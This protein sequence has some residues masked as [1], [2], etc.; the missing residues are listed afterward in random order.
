[1]ISGAGEAYRYLS[2]SIKSFVS[3]DDIRRYAEQAGLIGVVSRRL[4][5][6]ITYI[7][8]GVKA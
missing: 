8:R 7:Y 4:T 1:L 2:E 5:G 6:G 3:H